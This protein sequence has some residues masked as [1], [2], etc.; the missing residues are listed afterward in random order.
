M[1]VHTGMFVRMFVRELLC[2]L[3]TDW[4]QTWHECR[5]R[6]R[7]HL[8]LLVSMATFLLSWQPKKGDLFGQISIAA[9]R[10]IA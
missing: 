1:F 2:H 3:R 6:D 10:D 5:A 7:K 8:R 4:H 9:G